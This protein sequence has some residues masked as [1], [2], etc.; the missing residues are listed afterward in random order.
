MRPGR[1]WGTDYRRQIGPIHL[2][3]T[4]FC[5]HHNW[6]RPRVRKPYNQAKQGDNGSYWGW[7]G[8]W[9][10]FGGYVCSRGLLLLLGATK[11]VFRER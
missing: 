11:K 5:R 9:T 10:F 6:V 7:T 3:S 4:N 2:S 1:K 8:R